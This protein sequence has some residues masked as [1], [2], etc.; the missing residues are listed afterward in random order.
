MNRR[1]C[2]RC[3]GASPPGGGRRSEP[4]DL[5]ACLGD[6]CVRGLATATAPPDRSRQ[7]PLSSTMNER[8]WM[9][10]TTL[11]S[12]SLVLSRTYCRVSSWS[13]SLGTRLPNCWKRVPTIERPVDTGGPATCP[14]LFASPA[15]LFPG[16]R[17]VPVPS[18]SAHDHATGRPSLCRRTNALP[19]AAI[20]IRWCGRCC[21]NS[22]RLRRRLRIGRMPAAD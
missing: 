3:C 2:G 13:A 14:R 18:A 17:L 4:R 19:P 11:C 15:L 22:R 9:V 5:P 1:L 12:L 10:D 21:T 16:K 8:T 7:H 20:R 6:R